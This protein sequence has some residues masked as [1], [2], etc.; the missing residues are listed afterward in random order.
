MHTDKEYWT[1]LYPPVSPSEANVELFRHLIVGDTVLLLGSTKQLLDIAT[2]AYDL[3]PKYDSHKIINRDWRTLSSHFDT[4]IGDGV[5]NFSKDLTDEVLSLA[6]KY[7]Q[8]LVV[9]SFIKH[10]TKPKYATNWPQPDAFA[11]TPK[12]IESSEFYNF[13]VWDF[14]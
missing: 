7:S 8:R 6:S 12:I 2:T 9:R 11:I 5:F 10:P 13:Y 4:I 14:K 1:T 3:C